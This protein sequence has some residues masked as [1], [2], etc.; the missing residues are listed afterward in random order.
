MK[1][2]RSIALIVLMIALAAII[3]T[4]FYLGVIHREARPAGNDTPAGAPPSS[5]N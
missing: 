1:R 3:G 5:G 2:R 4:G